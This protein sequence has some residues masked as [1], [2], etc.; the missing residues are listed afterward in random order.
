VI[1][2]APDA[3]EFILKTFAS[4]DRFYKTPFRPKTY[5]TNFHPLSLDRKNNIY[6]LIYKCT[7]DKILDYKRSYLST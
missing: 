1:F 4:R 2:P 3:K 5:R 6:K 7:M